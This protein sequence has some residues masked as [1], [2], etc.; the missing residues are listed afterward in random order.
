M[1]K[2]KYPTPSG[3]KYG[4]PPP[5]R[6]TC[7]EMHYLARL[8]KKYGRETVSDI[9]AEI[10]LPRNRGRPSRGND[11][12]YEAIHLAQWFEEAI[13]ENRAIGVPKPVLAAELELGARGQ[14]QEFATGKFHHDILSREWRLDGFACRRTRDT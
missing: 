14:M 7:N 5:E 8:V 2:K 10:P 6:P 3:K 4:R 9:V 11:P 12:I 13:E 1:R